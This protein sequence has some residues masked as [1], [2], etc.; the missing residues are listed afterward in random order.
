MQ[1]SVLSGTLFGFSGGTPTV[2]ISAGRNITFSNQIDGNIII[3]AG[4]TARFIAGTS[5]TNLHVSGQGQLIIM[6]SL[7]ITGV[8]G[9]ELILRA[10]LT[11]NR[12]YGHLEITG[13]GRCDA[14]AG[15]GIILSDA[16]Y[17]TVILTISGSWDIGAC[18]PSARYSA[19]SQIIFAPATPQTYTLQ[20]GTWQC[21]VIANY[22]ATLETV[23]PIVVAG[24]YN[25]S[26]N[27]AL[28]IN[29]D[30]TVQGDANI[31]SYVSVNGS[32]LTIHG[33]LDLPAVS[34]LAIHVSSTKAP[35][36]SSRDM[37]LNGALSV[38]TVG[39]FQIDA[40]HEVIAVIY[41]TR[42]GGFR[43]LTVAAEVAGFNT[44]SNHKTTLQAVSPFAIPYEAN[45]AV[46]YYNSSGGT[47]CPTPNPDPSAGAISLPSLFNFL[48]ASALW[49]ALV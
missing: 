8:L 3:D 23:G 41:T 16:S 34:E 14:A 30:F 21:D 38:Y 26:D 24:N 5:S 25:A 1:G 31:E 12:N 37:L 43:T 47:P 42:T 19:R 9:S 32:D 22:F 4:A 49:M 36:I 29:K 17:E 10:P 35:R 46:V 2:H 44:N 28:F 15:G 20:A 27:T 33:D 18:I 45:Q 13:P 40:A 39:S 7:S 6:S 48:L 11:V